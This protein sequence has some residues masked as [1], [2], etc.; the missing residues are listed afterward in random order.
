MGSKRRIESK[1]YWVNG[2]TLVAG[3]ATLIFGSDMGLD[4]AAINTIAAGIVAFLPVV[5]MILREVT[6]KPIAR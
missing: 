2:L 1:T 4:E 6:G 5:N 3:G